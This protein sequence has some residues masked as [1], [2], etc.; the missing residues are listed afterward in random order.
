MSKPNQTNQPIQKAS[1]GA[2]APKFFMEDL[3]VDFISLVDKGA[4]K[5]KFKIYK[6]AEGPREEG[7]GSVQQQPLTKNGEHMDHYGSTAMG[8]GSSFKGA[9]EAIATQE[10]LYESKCTLDEYFFLLKMVLQGILNDESKPNKSAEI[11]KS[12]EE[13]K[14]ATLGLFDGLSVQKQAELLGMD[15]LNEGSTTNAGGNAGT[16]EGGEGMS[17]QQAGT[18]STAQAGDAVAK[19]AGASGGGE[20]GTSSNK[21][22]DGSNRPSGDNAAVEGIGKGKK[23]PKMMKAEIEQALKEGKSAEYLAEMLKAIGDGSEG[24]PATGRD[25]VSS[26]GKEATTAPDHVAKEAGAAAAQ[27]AAAAPVKKDDVGT[28][29]QAQHT[30]PMGGDVSLEGKLGALLDKFEQKIEVTLEG[31]LGAVSELV[32]GLGDRVGKIESVAKMAGVSN[33]DS[34]DFSVNEKNRN[35]VA[36]SEDAEWGKNLDSTG[37]FRKSQPAAR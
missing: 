21:Q 3:E 13:F 10:Q 6:R 4:N 19:A 25:G 32:K 15:G 37:G 35:E 11:K 31:K 14:V 30:P 26:N 23:D 29:A 33:A 12:I 34:F 20:A 9:L 17:Q 7:V 22:P 36:K 18:A 8:Y 1:A 2:V 5:K 27:P 16:S 28:D 24:A